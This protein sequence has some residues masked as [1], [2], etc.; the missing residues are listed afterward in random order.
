MSI[1]VCVCSRESM[2]EC[3]NRDGLCTEWIC[4][5]VG[6]IF[7]LFVVS[8][9]SVSA[10]VS[11]LHRFISPSV[12]LS[13][14]LSN[15][16]L[17]SKTKKIFRTT[18]FWTPVCY[19]GEWLYD[20]LGHKRGRSVPHITLLTLLSHNHIK[21]TACYFLL[22]VIWWDKHEHKQTVKQLLT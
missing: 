8:S 17:M 11:V 22:G 1:W 12:C 10:S 3:F 2:S 6:L 18:A 4:F 13:G 20:K 16:G 15:L 14:F 9:V 5:P 21:L 19:N 7:W